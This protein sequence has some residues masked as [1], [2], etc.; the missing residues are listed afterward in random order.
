MTMKAMGLKI[1]TL[2]SAV[3]ILRRR[4][5]PEATIKSIEIGA[6]GMETPRGKRRESTMAAVV[7]LPGTREK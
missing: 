1:N 5:L 6:D 3:E 2:V 7:N 4:I